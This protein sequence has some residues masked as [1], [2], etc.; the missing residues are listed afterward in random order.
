M[1]RLSRSR[2]DRRSLAITF[3]PKKSPW[4]P[5]RD[6]ASNSRERCPGSPSSTTASVPVPRTS[7]PATSAQTVSTEAT[8][9]RSDKVA[10]ALSTRSGP[11]LEERRRTSPTAHA[12]PASSVPPETTSVPDTVV[13]SGRS[14]ITADNAYRVALA[15]SSYRA[16]GS[17]APKRA[18]TISTPD[19]VPNSAVIDRSG[20][21]PVTV[22]LPA[23]SPRDARPGGSR[24][25]DDR[26]KGSRSI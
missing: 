10:A 23:T 2:V 6:S 4:S 3:S 25:T 24:T 1:S 13:V 15:L 8:P 22:T 14:G 9:P 19:C 17:L 18:S 16:N 7:R 11:I 5:T 20:R 21:G 26:S 12:T